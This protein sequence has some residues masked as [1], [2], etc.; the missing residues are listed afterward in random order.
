[1][2]IRSEAKQSI[3]HQLIKVLSNFKQ[4]MVTPLSCSNLHTS[5][6][7]KIV[8]VS[9]EG[10]QC[11]SQISKFK[12]RIQKPIVKVVHDMLTK[13]WIFIRKDKQLEDPACR[14]PFHA[15]KLIVA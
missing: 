2:V 13:K 12:I 1:L 3:R 15:M 4:N 5:C 10:N 7:K 8:S 14:I 11:R 6:R 9:S